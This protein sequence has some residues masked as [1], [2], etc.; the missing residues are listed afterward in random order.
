MLLI[1]F[2]FFQNR[3][4]KV[5]MI[6]RVGEILSFETNATHGVV[7]GSFFSSDGVET[8]AANIDMYRRLV[9]KNLHFYIGYRTT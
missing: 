7:I 1:H 5:R 9:C 2:P 6:W 8:I 4:R 3:I